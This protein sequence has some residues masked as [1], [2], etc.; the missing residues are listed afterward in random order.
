MLTEENKEL[1]ARYF[2]KN[3]DYYIEQIESYNESKKYSFN[4]SAFFLG[5][6]WMTYR[7]M[8]LQAV[9]VIIM[10]LIESYL[11]DILVQLNFISINT[12]EI[13]DKGA[14]LI[15]GIIIGSI[16]NRL[17][18]SKTKKDIKKILDENSDPRKIDEL[19]QK[20]GGTNWN[21]PLTVLA[22]LAIIIILS[23]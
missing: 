16:S 1:Y 8:Y 15:W 9:V 14:M 4:I 3:S 13:I 5:I 22:L 20:K 18:I 12:Y 23:I 10:I 17:Y 19:I 21:G 6:F 7:K 2:Q 11:E